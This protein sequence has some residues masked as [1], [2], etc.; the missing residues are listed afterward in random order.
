MWPS[1]TGKRGGGG[2]GSK[3]KMKKVGATATMARKSE[4][5]TWN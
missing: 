1:E 3:G 5:K 4:R 2:G